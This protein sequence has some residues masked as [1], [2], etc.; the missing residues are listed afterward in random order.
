MGLYLEVQMRYL[1][2][3][4]ALLLATSVSAEPFENCPAK[5]FLTQGTVP[6]TYSVNLVTGDYQVLAST[7][8]VKSGI[9]ALGYN[10]QDNYAYGWSYQHNLP[11]RIHNEF[12]VEP[13][14]VDN[15]SGV[16]FYVG[17]VSTND[18][19]YYVY[20]RGATAGLFS[21]DLDASSQSFLKMEQ[22]VDG[23]TL[24][25]DIA[26]MAFHPYTD[27]AYSVD[28]SGYLLEIDVR[29]G[30][31][32]KLDHVGTT[33]GFGAA[34][35]D[36]DGNLYMG[37]NRDGAIYRINIDS[38]IYQAEFFAKGPSSSTN[39]GFRCAQAPV[40]GISNTDL[41]FGDAPD[42]YGT[43]IAN[44]GARHG[45]SHKNVFYLGEHVDGESDASI[46]PLSDDNNGDKKDDDG[47]QFATNI[48]ESSKAIAVVKASTTGYL[49]AWIDLD[50]NGQF[51]DND[52]VVKDLK[53]KMGNQYVYMPI[54]A[55]VKSGETWAR[56]RFS[57]S[58][59]IQAVGGAS[60]GEVE[61]YKVELIESKAT[62]ATYP[63]SNSWTTLAF[64]DNWPHEGDYD[65]NDLVVHMRTSVW[66]KTSGVTQVN[67][68][69]EISAVGASYHNG[70]AV[71][72]PGV[73]RDQVD[74][75]NIEYLVN[76]QPVDFEPLETGRDEAIFILTYNLWDY[77]GSGEL[78]K[79][80]RTE[81]GCGSD[82]Q[83]NFSA[84]I[85]M[86]EP[87]QAN[88]NGVFDPFLF[89]T[90]GAWHG[91]H[92]A[93]TPGRSYEIHLKNYAPTE[94]FDQSLFDAPGDDAS[95]PDN[96]FFFTTAKGMPWALEI[97]TRWDHPQEYTDIGHAY[98]YF[99]SWA[100]SNGWAN[101]DWYLNNN[102]NAPLLF[103]D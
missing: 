5:A 19:K 7:M 65:M 35:F 29:T 71:R 86:K 24:D 90:P 68:K 51:D 99:A 43:S 27:L 62:V 39:D 98:P 23:A 88:L 41:D 57:E 84:R 22:V 16:D 94:A 70:F 31:A 95:A 54:P 61:D 67:M 25:M 87:V 89:A 64:E 81:D 77:V 75:E 93:T 101:Q 11:V 48:V 66:S 4:S 69:G 28:H 49:N 73:K 40:I 103:I 8:G 56:F 47:V 14:K 82:I 45:L 53:V 63:S 33:A 13:L 85:P 26:D 9:N 72:L 37:R 55:G 50:Q 12:N 78:C 32:T 3:A 83:M 2:A 91:G 97:G 80:Y 79:Y 76:G 34:Y 96:S 6:S 42:T 60:N 21:I 59:G 36:A 46:D 18:N 44:N 74:V 38:G 102:A 52:Q 30:T 58:D 92:F 15:V 100:L 1:L 10:S 20:R 17:D